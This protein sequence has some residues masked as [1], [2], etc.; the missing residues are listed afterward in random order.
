MVF[1]CT[2]EIDAGGPKTPNALLF[3]ATFRLIMGDAA[4]AG[5]DIEALF[6]WMHTHADEIPAE[7]VMRVR[8]LG[9]FT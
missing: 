9:I 1:A 8:R 4:S 7:T 6:D 3:R 2:E 5:K